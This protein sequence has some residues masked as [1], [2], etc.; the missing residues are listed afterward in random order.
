MEMGP[1]VGN[2]SNE[3]HVVNSEVQSDKS[4]KVVGED[5]THEEEN[6]EAIEALRADFLETMTLEL[7]PDFELSDA[8]T[9]TGVMACFFDGKGMS[10]NRLRDVLSEVWKKL[11]GKWKFKT[12]KPSVW[13]IFFDSDDDCEEI[14]DKRPWLINGKLLIIHEWPEDGLWN[15]VDLS[16]AIFWVQA[17]GL[18]TPYL[19]LVNTPTIAAKAGVF[20]GSDI[21][22]KRT[23]YRRGFLKFQVEISTKHQ[24]L[25]G[26]FLDIYRGRKEWIQFRY[27]K[28]PKV[29]FNYGFLG[30]DKKVCLKLTTF[31]FLPEGKA[32]P[33]YDPWIRSE[34][35]V[36]SCFNTRNQLDFYRD[37]N[38]GPQRKPGLEERSSSRWKTPIAPA[39][40]KGKAP[41][42]DLQVTDRSYIPIDHAKQRS[43]AIE[44]LYRDTRARSISPR[45]LRRPNLYNKGTDGDNKII[46]KISSCPCPNPRDNGVLTTIMANLGPTYNQMIEKPH[47]DLCKSRQP[48]KHPEP[49]HFPWPTY[50]SEIGLTKDLMGPPAIDK[51]EPTP[52]NF[53][54]PPDVSA[55][56][57]DCPQPRKRKAS[58][59]LIPFVQR[60]TDNPF[61]FEA[62]TPILPPFSPNPNNLEF[63][64]SDLSS[65]S[66]SKRKIKRKRAT[67]KSLGK[68]KVTTANGVGEINTNP[69][70]N[71]EVGRNLVDDLNL[72]DVRVESVQNFPSGEEAALTMPPTVSLR[73][74]SWNCYGLARDT[75]IQA[76]RVWVGRH[77]PECVFLMETKSLNNRWNLV[78]VYGPLYDTEKTNFGEFLGS[79]SLSWDP[80]WLLIGD[81]NC[82][83]YS[84]EKI[85]GRKVCWKDTSVL[86][87]FL[88]ESGGIDLRS[89][90]CKF[91]WQ[92]KRFNGGLIREHL[93]RAVG[94]SN[95][96][97][98]NPKAGVR[99]FPVFVS[100]HGA[101][102][103]DTMM[104]QQRSYIPF[105]FFEAWA[106]S[107][108]C[109]EIIKENWTNLSQCPSIR[110]PRNS[111]NIRIHLSKWKKNNFNDMD[112]VIKELEDRLMCL[113][114]LSDGAT[115]GD[116]E[117][118]V[119]EDLMAAWL[120]KE[121]IWRQKYR[122]LWLRLGDRNSQ[123]F[124]ASASVR[125]RRNQI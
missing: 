44:K 102:L 104:F 49:T 66:T 1:E 48:Q 89:I 17:T 107:E 65:A 121:S 29:C 42:A 70:D 95:W 7:E 22:E 87:N 86:N 47:T 5:E 8:I 110:F 82:I 75:A 101:I 37:A 12:L 51:F 78:V 91:T 13:G 52:T 111:D 112:K 30:H 61:L 27:S 105:W 106:T 120:K 20:K 116:V 46:K 19:N 45:A 39:T 108:S 124:H 117:R 6:T 81:L 38:N 55:Q 14:L 90:G 36:F 31:A 18:P 60:L 118:R 64:V 3:P 69:S 68:N 74:L 123:F 80:S 92:N 96:I 26:F 23:I 9:R 32:V 2:T 40:E 59:T 58:L 24:L 79:K 4:P 56:V 11:K 119:Q 84:D 115:Q 16:K 103:M 35:A 62:E 34:S 85:G 25:A 114:N 94:S 53:H 83:G 88:R 100:D 67:S 97:N 93:D 43:P 28:L 21:V 109:A 77:K 57:H 98:D 50:A 72:V 15:N 76:L 41:I 99:N 113:Q 33:A 10:K 122:E 73:V 125:R 54:D 71:N 63:K